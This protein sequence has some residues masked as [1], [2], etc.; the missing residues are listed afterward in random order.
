MGAEKGLKITIETPDTPIPLDDPYEIL[1]VYRDESFT[2]VP[3]SDNVERRARVNELLTAVDT[4]LTNYDIRRY[5][6]YGDEV[7]ATLL[8]GELNPLLIAEAA[9]RLKERP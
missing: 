2:N 6:S 1:R 3:S 8:E 7:I 4:C 5:H 9:R